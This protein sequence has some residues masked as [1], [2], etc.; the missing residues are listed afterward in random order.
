L[1]TV[2]AGLMESLM[3]RAFPTVPNV[4]GTMGV[5]PLGGLF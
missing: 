5:G 2:K 3:Q 4:F 1:D